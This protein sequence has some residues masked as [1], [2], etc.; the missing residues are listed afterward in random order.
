[1]DA[2]VGR[3]RRRRAE[4]LERAPELHV[5]HGALVRLELAQP[6]DRVDADDRRVDAWL[7]QREVQ[8][9]RGRLDTPLRAERPEAIDVRQE[10][11]ARFA[12]PVGASAEVVTREDAGAE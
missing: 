5:D 6:V 4:G 3:W 8:R 11:G 2:S 9:G 10:L 1:A 12:V 7:A